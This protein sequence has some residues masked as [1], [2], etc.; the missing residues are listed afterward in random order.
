MPLSVFYL[1]MKK[2]K[3]NSLEA[4]LAEKHRIHE[5]VKLQEKELK[6]R[7]T[8]FQENSRS[9]IWHQINPFKDNITISSI[10]NYL[11]GELFPLVAGLDIEKKH[12]AGSK[13]LAKGLRFAL[14]TGG[15]NLAKK[16]WSNRKTEAK[17]S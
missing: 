9:I 2:I 12:P 7:A 10:L 17:E 1:T 16:L 4:L 3:K 8:F 14:I 6:E 15:L 5:V 13:L 11:T